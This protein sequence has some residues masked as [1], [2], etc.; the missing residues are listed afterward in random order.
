MGP[1]Q[2]LPA[3]HWRRLLALALCLGL[4]TG[5]SGQTAPAPQ[6]APREAHC[7]LWG[8]PDRVGGKPVCRRRAAPPM[9][10]PV[11][12]R[13]HSQSMG[14]ETGDKMCIYRRPGLGGGDTTVSVPVAT[15]CSA[16]IRC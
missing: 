8:P 5:A 9:A 11:L 16:A 1:T 10:A 13:L 15:P 2:I 7:L 3:L 14:E 4:A 6:A 12:C